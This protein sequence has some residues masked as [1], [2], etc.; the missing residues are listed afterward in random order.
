MDATHDTLCTSIYLLTLSKLQEPKANH[1]AYKTIVFHLKANKQSL[2][3]LSALKSLNIVPET[4][5]LVFDAC[6][7][8]SPAVRKYGKLD[9]SLLSMF[10]GRN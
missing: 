1:K 10:V 5:H 8:V 9:S 2:V 6:R 7:D 4:Q 3:R